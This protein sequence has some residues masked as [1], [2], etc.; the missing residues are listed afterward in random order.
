M[1]V[2]NQ[3]KRATGSV[4][5]RATSASQGADLSWVDPEGLATCSSDRQAT[6]ENSCVYVCVCVCVGPGGSDS[7]GMYTA[8]WNELVP[9]QYYNE[10]FPVLRKRAPRE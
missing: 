2:A 5:R 10:N 1:M 3:D 9:L 4:V 6:T 7:R 8:K